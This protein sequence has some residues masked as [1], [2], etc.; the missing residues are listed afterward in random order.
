MRPPAGPAAPRCRSLWPMGAARS[1]FRGRRRSWRSAGARRGGRDFLRVRGVGER[2]PR[3]DGGNGSGRDLRS[4]RGSGRR[5]QPALSRLARASP[6]DRL[7]VRFDP[8]AA[9]QPA[10]P[11]GGLR[12][13]GVLGRGGEAGFRSS[14]RGPDRAPGALP[15]APGQP[16]YRGTALRSRTLPRRWRASAHERRSERS[17]SPHPSTKFQTDKDKRW[18]FVIQRSRRRCRSGCRLS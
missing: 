13:G 7:R 11:Q 15:G 14:S 16:D 4:G 18:I 10:S 3:G 5:R 12:A 9:V 6:R 17:C 2:G 8:R 1:P